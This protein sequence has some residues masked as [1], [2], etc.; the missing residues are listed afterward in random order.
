MSARWPTK[1]M[2]AAL[3]RKAASVGV[4]PVT[5]AR[6]LILEEIGWKEPPVEPLENPGNLTLRF[7]HEQMRLLKQQAKKNQPLSTLSQYIFDV[8]AKHTEWDPE[9]DPDFNPRYLR[10]SKSDE[11]VS[12]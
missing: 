11:E 5:L 4:A 3:D 10:G 8:L 6:W 2:R 7:T 9:K 1:R 12:E